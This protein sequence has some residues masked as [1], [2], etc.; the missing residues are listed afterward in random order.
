MSVLTGRN[1]AAICFAV[2]LG[3]FAAPCLAQEGGEGGEAPAPEILP[4]PE[5]EMNVD[6]V[7]KDIHTVMHYIAY[8][9]GLKIIVEGTV[10][11]KLTVMFP[12]VKPKDAIRAICKANKL[13]FIED[14]EYII[15]KARQSD[16]Q[17]A[18]VVAGA[19]ASDGDRFTAN[20]EEHP[21]VRAIME[22]GN[23]TNTDVYVPAVPVMQDGRQPEPEG[24][25]P[26]GGGE[27]LVEDVQARKISMYMRDAKPADL[28]QRLADLGDMDVKPSSWQ[29]RVKIITPEGEEQEVEQTRYGY[30]FTYRIRVPSGPIAGGSSGSVKDEDI[31]S[32]SWTLPGADVAGLK[33][34]V[35][36]LLS[37]FGKVV[38]DRTTSYLA[39]FDLESNKNRVAAFINMV[40][41]KLPEVQAA[42]QADK[43][44]EVIV[45]RE[46][47]ITRNAADTQILNALQGVMSDVGRVIS[48]VDRNSLIV[49]E[50]A[51][52]I[53][54][55]DQLMKSMD[56]APE[57]VLITAKLIEVTLD[58]YM[59][60]GLELFTSQPADNLNDGVFT[61]SSEDT[62]NTV[63]GLFGQPTG[64][65]PFF[66]T[67]SNPRLD[68]RLELLA[69]DGRV[70]TLSQPTQ[71]VSNRRPARIEV[72]QE[73][74]YLEASSQ[75]GGTTTASVS[76]K[77]VSI[78]MDVTPTV[79]EGGLVRLEVTVTVR[80]VVG[81]VAIEGNNTPV[82]SKRESR[83]DVFINDGE[84]LV[85]GGLMRERERTDE[86]GLPFLKD[87]PII[88]YLFKSAN[89]STS[90][91]DLLFFVRPTIVSAN[92][93]RVGGE[94]D[95]ERDIR[96]IIYA[97]GDEKKADI[98][99]GRFRKMGVA[100]KPA[101]YNDKNRPKS[102][103]DVNP[104][105]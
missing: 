39:V 60:Y 68:V 31:K 75:G 99:Q 33:A 90:K 27:N 4:D 86:N 37:P 61:G 74:P 76:F 87:I 43:A 71:M 5:A 77:E 50:R 2:L 16:Q 85:M 100:P 83:T 20:F 70:R 65:D 35:T 44:K 8:R 59:G 15:I 97:D 47:R 24:Q 26:G 36:N 7:Q 12:R 14:G 52:N 28:L 17:L 67:F 58:S 102:P 49:W 55:V 69:N 79:L 51:S 41:A 56:T 46:Y 53:D 1:L 92:G 11:V 63:G 30:M 57:Q 64:F 29:V 103:K 96:P 19:K 73:I 25:Q 21:L 42:A 22:V 94:L 84:T 66:G 18:N 95:L 81:N 40:E 93:P 104:G 78:V 34:E 101:W 62:T 80:E 88:G 54:N 6:F 3:V 32:Q 98:R 72:G 23:V 105:A 89:K 48:N 10:T 45:V 13:D 38:I 82:L 91:T 9:S